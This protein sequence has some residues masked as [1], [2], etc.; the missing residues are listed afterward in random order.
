MVKASAA[1]EVVLLSAGGGPLAIAAAS[2]TMSRSKASFS[3]ASVSFR[4]S[5]SSA[6]SSEPVS[7]GESMASSSSAAAAL[8][9]AWASQGSS[10]LFSCSWSDSCSVVASLA[11]SEP[12]SHEYEPASS[13][14]VSYSDDVS[15]RLSVSSGVGGGRWTK[16][17]YVP[18]SSDDTYI[19]A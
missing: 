5:S 18:I 4:V 7:S 19:M 9:E 11:P 1:L 15:R 14:S 2:M 12:C 10:S 6:G 16:E 3:A 17:A 8:A 13:P